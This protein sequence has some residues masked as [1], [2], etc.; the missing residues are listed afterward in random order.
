MTR[1]Q[2]ALINGLHM[3]SHAAYFLAREAREAG[4][5]HEYLAK[6]LQARQLAEDAR[7]AAGCVEALTHKAERIDYELHLRDVQLEWAERE[8]SYELKKRALVGAQEALMN[9]MAERV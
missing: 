7:I 5:V 6:A 3:A 1:A 8:M 9:A 4:N 2:S